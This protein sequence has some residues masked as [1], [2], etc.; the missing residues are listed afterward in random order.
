LLWL[1]WR[2]GCLELYLLGWPQTVIFLISASQV[3][4][5]IDGS[6]QHSAKALI[7][8]EDLNE[9]QYVGTFQRIGFPHRRP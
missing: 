2:W 6:H 3:A 5:I 1:F 8:V 7:I 9:L 4:R